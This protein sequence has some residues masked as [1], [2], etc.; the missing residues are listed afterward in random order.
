M[1]EGVSE[2]GQKTT[3]VADVHTDANTQQA[4]EEGVGYVDL[5]LVAYKLPTG[6]IY[7]GAGPVMSHYEFKQDMSNRLTDE[8]WQEMLEGGNEPERA[9]WTISFI[10]E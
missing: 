8:G 3:I 4:L 9:P 5:M 2:K 10:S 7:I 1:I 6:E